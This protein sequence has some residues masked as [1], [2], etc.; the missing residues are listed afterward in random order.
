MFGCDDS[1]GEW[2]LFARWQKKGNSF[3]RWQKKGNSFARWQKRKESR[4]GNWEGMVVAEGV[5]ALGH[6][7]YP[8]FFIFVNNCVGMMYHDYGDRRDLSQPYYG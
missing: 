4:G 8:N 5:V 6:A 1:D 2:T 7:S 3:A